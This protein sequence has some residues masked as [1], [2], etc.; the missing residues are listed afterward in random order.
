LALVPQY[1]SD[2][3]LR[4]AQSL[5]QTRSS[6]SCAATMSAST[7]ARLGLT[8]GTPVAITQGDCNAQMIAEI[9]NSLAD[10]T[11]RIDSARIE[12]SRLGAMYGSVQLQAVSLVTASVAG[13]A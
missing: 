9:D 1:R 8:A 6:L 12:T 5:Q 2:A 13:A 7:L 11:V 3:I 4:R 10:N